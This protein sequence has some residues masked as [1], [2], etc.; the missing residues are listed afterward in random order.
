METNKIVFLE[1][2]RVICAIAVVLDHIAIAA[3][4]IFADDATVFEKCAYNG[5]Q[6]WSHF[7]VPVFLMI[8]GFLL[9]NPNKPIDYKKSISKYAKRMIIVLLVIGTAFAYMELFF[10]NRSFAIYDIGEAIY[11]V[12]IGKTWDHMWYLYVLI[13]IY[14]V[15][16]VLRSIFQSLPN[17][18]IDT[19]LLILFIFSSVLPTINAMTGFSLGIQIPITSIY[20]FYFLIGRRLA[21]LDKTMV[22]RI[23][24]SHVCIIC[25]MLFPILFAWLE[26][27]KGLYQFAPL[28]GY[29]SPFVVALSLA[30]FLF[31]KDKNN[32]LTNIYNRG[33]YLLKHIS[34]NSFGIYIFHMLWVNILYKIVKFNPLDYNVIVLI[35]IVLLVL[36]V[37]DVT[38]ILYRKIPVIGKYI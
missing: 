30:I 6:H 9:L 2:L 12:L 16:P 20:L 36:I 31:A 3:I 17:N 24:S 1:Y 7:A 14:L 13:G 25:L 5:I 33:G 35:P 11:N 23:G 10:K 19:F 4:H 27:A 15:L 18:I 8:S 26:N 28:S 32:V 21:T 34:D 38:T 22:T 37:S 29:A